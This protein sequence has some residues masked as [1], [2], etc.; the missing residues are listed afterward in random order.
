MIVTYFE[1]KFKLD[2]F[3][4]LYNLLLKNSKIIDN[5]FYFI[6]SK[7]PN[8]NDNILI[9]YNYLYWNYFLLS[10][11]YNISINFIIKNRFLN[12][13]W[14]EISNNKDLNL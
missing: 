11:N 13:N 1:K 4:F 12:W 3:I 14:E 9:N 2:R 8:I 5:K 7:S 6:L 10:S